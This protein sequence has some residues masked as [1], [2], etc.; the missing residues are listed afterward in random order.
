MSTGEGAP[1]AK[2]MQIIATRPDFSRV[3]KAII[4]TQKVLAGCGEMDPRTLLVEV[5]N[6][7]ATV[8]TVWWVLKK[9]NRVT[10]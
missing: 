2:E 4:N 9:L 3:R 1:I 5:S 8:E 10:I 6:G 7:A